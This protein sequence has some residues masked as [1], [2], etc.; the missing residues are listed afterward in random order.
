MCRCRGECRS[1]AEGGEGSLL[2]LIRATGVK[3]FSRSP[4]GE[5]ELRGISLA[6]IL[7]YHPLSLSLSLLEKS[8]KSSSLHAPTFRRQE[9][10]AE[11]LEAK[12][13]LESLLSLQAPHIGAKMAQWHAESGR[14]R[15]D[16][17]QAL[18]TSG[19]MLTTD[20]ILC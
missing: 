1:G 13:L 3:G 9:G 20:R 6:H 7:N 10:F 14:L 2:T 5:E 17:L 18:S 15:E 12:S 19:T 16:I 11:R 4:W 8:S